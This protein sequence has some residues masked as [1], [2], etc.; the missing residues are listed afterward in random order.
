MLLANNRT[1]RFNQETLFEVIVDFEGGVKKTNKTEYECEEGR[2]V[3]GHTCSSYL[4]SSGHWINH[5]SKI[6]CP[7][8]HALFRHNEY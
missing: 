6:H 2:K 7:R 4:T 5:V 3:S 1:S 8:M